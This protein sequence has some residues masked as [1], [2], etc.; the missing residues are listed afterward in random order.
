MNSKIISQV[1]S[2]TYLGVTITD[3]LSWNQ[4]CDIIC[5]KA[6]ST[7]GLLKR[8]LSGCSSQVKNTA[9]CSLVRPKLEYA[10]SAWNPYKQC[11]VKV[12]NTAYCSLVRPKLEYASSA[13]NPYK[14]CNVKV[15]NTA[16]CSL[17]RPKLEYASSAWNPYKQCN[18]KVKNTAY[19]SLVRPKLE[20]ASSAWNPY[21]QCNV[22]VKNTAYCSLVRPK[23]EYASSAWNPYKQCNVNKIEMVQRRAATFVNNDYSR[24]SSVS[25]MIKSLGWDSLERRRL[26]N[27]T[28]MFYKIYRGLVGISLPSEI[29]QVT[30]P[31]R[32][33][34]CVP[35]QQLCTLNDTYKY[36]FYPKTI[37]TW[38]NMNL[39][40]IPN[41][42]DD[43][44]ANVSL[45]I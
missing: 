38:N 39:P 22:K 12:K 3:N 15:K 9:Y 29:M 5:D 11:N 25:Q 33:L 32:Y 23:L 43:F 13:W 19:C 6:N 30:R 31:S 36:S 4:H 45:Y 21:K 28:C 2:T 41:S 18:V 26:I 10:S 14:Q 42:L 7:L 27:Q 37:R 34:N 35:F 8:I 1:P 20:Y 16:Y 24:H 40:Q 44:K 17:V